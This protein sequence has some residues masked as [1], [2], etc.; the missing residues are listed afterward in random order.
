MHPLGHGLRI[1]PFDIGHLESGGGCTEDG[2]VEN[3]APHAWLAWDGV[4]LARPDGHSMAAEWSV[5][6]AYYCALQRF[7]GVRLLLMR[8]RFADVVVGA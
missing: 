2:A 3:C 1:V 7:H 5:R 4:S 6:V 8:T